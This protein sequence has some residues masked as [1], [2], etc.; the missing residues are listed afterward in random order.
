VF[1]L[2]L[3]AAVLN[4]AIAGIQTQCLCF[5]FRPSK[6]EEHNEVDWQAV[7]AYALA[8]ASLNTQA[9]CSQS[10]CLD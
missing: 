10:L 8:T 7:W 5:P 3:I 1:A 4:K 2:Q 6:V 9:W